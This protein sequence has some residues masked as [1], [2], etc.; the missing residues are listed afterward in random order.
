MRFTL[1]ILKMKT[2]TEKTQDIQDAGVF[3]G[4]PPNLFEDAGRKMLMVLLNEGLLPYSKVLD[5]GC[6]CLRGGYWTIRFLNSNCYF[7]IEPNKTMLKTG[8]KCLFSE[9]TLEYKQPS[10]DHNESFNASVFNTRFDYFLAR[11]IWT[12]ASK[13][14]IILMLDSFINNG[15]SRSVFLTSFINAETEMEEYLGDAWIG[16]SHESNEAGIVKHSFSWIES[17][18]LKRGLEAQIIDND[19]FDL[20]NNQRWIKITK[21]S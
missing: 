15:H 21:T 1:K 18:C 9:K 10:F 4:G 20:N 11:S 12:H 14:Q 6:G 13:L 7:G 19:T 3:L 16:K 2:L 5:I 17:E 8:L